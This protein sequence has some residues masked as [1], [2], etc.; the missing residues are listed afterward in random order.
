MSSVV[1]KKVETKKE[2]KAF[3]EF[4][5]DLYEGNEFD[6]PTLFNDDFNTLSKDKNAAFDFCESEYYLAC[7][8]GKVVG[9]VAAIINH[10]AN[11]KWNRKDVRFGWIDFVDDME[12][13]AALLKAV[14]DWGR[15]RGMKEIVGPL[16][17]TD[18]DPEGMLTWGFDK[19]G[20]MATIYNYPY[21]PRHMETL[22]GWEKDN[23]YVEYFLEVPEQVPEKYAKIAE[24]IENRYNLHV[25]KL[26]KK[27][28]YQ[29][30]YG[31][32]LFALIND[33]YQDLYG[34][35]ELT[36]R[37]I[38]QYVNMYIPVVDLN[39]ITVVE[40]GN[41]DN[42]LVAMGITIPSLSRALQK[43]RRGRLWP[44]GWWY[45]LRAIK[46][47]KTE[48]VDLL[49]MGVLPEY[50]AKGANALLFA[51]LIPR[52]QAYGIKWGESQ[53]EMENN[54]GVQSQWGPLNPINHKRR[55]CYKK[56]L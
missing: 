7:R 12:V 2:L 34:F 47:H 55:R 14:E 32:K 30:G 26:T 54:E 6:V 40:D 28:I 13:S 49:L 31:H 22:G 16:G 24:M 9:R 23:D 17:F 33:T 1:V 35:S 27:D 15:A 11:E 42:K 46:C 20:T 51:D 44:L 38:D 5:Y 56:S 8:D 43:C 18:M 48:G 4:H 3:I 36:Q 50:R 45:L 29:G 25:R 53:V 10:R 21:Y 41:A 19:L 39:L 52:Y 37:Q